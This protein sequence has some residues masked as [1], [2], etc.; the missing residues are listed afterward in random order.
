MLLQ[1]IYFAYS[2]GG[3]REISR[4]VVL[5]SCI[6]VTFRPFYFHA[7]LYIDILKS[8][9]QQESDGQQ[10]I[11]EEPLPDMENVVNILVRMSDGR[12]LSRRFLKSDKL[13]VKTCM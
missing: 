10:H 8:I 1:N 9:T 4:T 13:K 3:A 6:K 5:L 11:P 7:S 2:G 12:R